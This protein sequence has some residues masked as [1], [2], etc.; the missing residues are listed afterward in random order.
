VGTICQSVWRLFKE[1]QMNSKDQRYF[2]RSGARY[3]MNHQKPTGKF[4]YRTRSDSHVVKTDYNVLRH[5]GSLYSLSQ[6]R[7]L[8]DAKI[9]QTID[10]GIEYLWRWYLV[11]VPG[12]QMQ[13]AIASARP[14][15]R[16]DDIA[17]IGAMGLALITISSLGRSWT[18]F[19]ADAAAGIARYMLSLV[20][21]N[22]TMIFKHNYRTGQVSDFISLYYPG[23]VALGLLLYGVRQGDQEATSVALKILMNLAKARRLKKEV[24]VDHWAL[25]ATGEVFKLASAGKIEISE[26]YLD[27]FYFHG[28]QVLNEI[29]KGSENPYMEIGSLVGNG[30]CCS[31]AT[32]LEG[33]TAMYPLMK[34]RADVAQQNVADLIEIGIS[35]LIEA[36]FREGKLKGGVPWISQHHPNFMKVAQ[37]PEVRIDT[38]QHSISAVLGGLA[39]RQIW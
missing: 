2:V 23:E 19:D 21:S 30:R 11:P 35:H 10:R 15:K 27:A 32:R 28:I 6:S 8:L 29:I 17:K 13:Y 34:D 14:G 5:I 4:I 31:I 24:P 12:P 3:L 18:K 37:A 1:K 22:G 33:L 38:V 9:N 20:R 16:N 36:Q 39:L 26:E 7:S 25:L